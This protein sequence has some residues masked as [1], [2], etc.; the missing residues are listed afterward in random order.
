MDYILAG[1]LV[2]AGVISTL[3][4]I[5]VFHYGYRKDKEKDKKK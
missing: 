4:I 3:I 2:L 1:L 5:S